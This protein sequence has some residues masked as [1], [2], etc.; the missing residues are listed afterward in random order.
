MKILRHAQPTTLCL[1]PYHYKFNKYK[2]LYFV[3]GNS[4]ILCWIQNFHFQSENKQ[5]NNNIVE[6]KM[7][8]KVDLPMIEDINIFQQRLSDT[9]L[10]AV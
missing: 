6:L 7:I 1:S 9:K 2:A 5:N 4:H 10:F 3:L 8:K